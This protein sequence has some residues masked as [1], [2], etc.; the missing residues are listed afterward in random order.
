MALPATQMA[1]RTRVLLAEDETVTRRLLEAQMTR[2]GFEVL[3]VADGLSAWEVL[4]SPDAPSLV[5][6]DWNM[7]GLDGPDICRRLRSS[8]RNSYTYM[9]LVTARNAKSDVV[10]G[11]QAGADD[12][13]SK[14]VD[15]D[16]LHARLRTGER[17][18]HLEQTLGRQV[19]EL[20]AAAEHV[21]EL[22]GMIPICMHCKRI[23]NQEQIWEKV[24]T[25]IEQRSDA[26][27]SHALCA[28]C[29]EQHYPDTEKP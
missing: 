22:Q 15:P 14:P 9:L 29:L 18:V 20:Q 17:I 3:S 27:F 26:K 21:R 2:F 24:E 23:R 6:L 4:Q 8:V 7:P 5:V 10:Q 28:E 12:F 13:I 25:Y 16:E 11:L 19:K 1:P